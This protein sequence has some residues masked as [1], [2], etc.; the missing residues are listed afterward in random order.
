MNQGSA[1]YIIINNY[2]TLFKS[3]HKK[4]SH[5][6]YGFFQTI[7]IFLLIILKV[8]VWHNF[9][10]FSSRRRLFTFLHATS[11]ALCNFFFVL[12][13]ATYNSSSNFAFILS[14]EY[15][16]AMVIKIKECRECINI[17]FYFH[18]DCT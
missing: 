15:V 13:F 11:R 18:C 8:R 16:C 12:K 7:P 3:L 10:L 5:H 6:H 2:Q 1:L 4:I 17:V 9:S 14:I